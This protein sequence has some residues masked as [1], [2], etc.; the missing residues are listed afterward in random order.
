MTETSAAEAGA[1]PALLLRIGWRNLA[2]NRRRTW[3]TAGGIA[4]AV[5]LVV[6]SMAMQIGQYDIMMENA[7]SLLTGHIQV[8]AAE[9]VDSSR[10]EDTMQ[11][12]HAL[13]HEIEAIP[14]VESVAPRAEAFALASVGERS[15]GARIIG[16]DPDAER[17]TVRL[18]KMVRE[19]RAIAGGDEGL[20]GA[21]LARNL[22]VGVGE[23]VVLLGSEKR[24]GVAALV[25][26]VVGI[27][28]TG[29]ADL[30]R[31]A[32][33]APLA[34]VQD[35][36]GLADEAHTFAIRTEDLELSEAVAE[37]L[38]QRLSDRPALEVRHWSEVMP[39]LRQAIEIDKLGAELFFYVVEVLVVFS[40]VNTFIMTV[41]ERTR[42]FGMLKAIGM[43]PWR[44]V[45]MMQWEGFFIW[46]LGASLGLGLAALVVAWLQDVGIYMGETLEEYAEQFYM[47]ARLYPAFS[48][49]AFISAPLV[50][51]F[52]TQIAAFLPALRILRLNTAAALRGE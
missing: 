52:G 35:A 33:I 49:E 15:F 3:L 14:G 44:I 10:L 16:V 40:I 47:P 34:S 46:V 30:D 7:T 51:L 23:E 32:L 9:Y 4:F 18:L 26:T 43:K 36:F 50:M 31:V 48:L 39:E 8:Q 17:S 2:R 13:R 21:S 11:A 24:G 28:E 19:G 6:F 38:K 20:L 25:L 5:L 27:L 42:E 37:R 22:G 45:A 1:R 41:F 12:A 29:V